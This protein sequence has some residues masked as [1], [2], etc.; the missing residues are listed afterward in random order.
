MKGRVTSGMQLESKVEDQLLSTQ[1]PSCLLPEGWVCLFTQSPQH[2]A[3]TKLLIN[4][5]L[6]H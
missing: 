5:E 3:Q 6:S 4:N 1:M 2:L